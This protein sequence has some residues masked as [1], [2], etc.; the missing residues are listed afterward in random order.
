MTMFASVD[1]LADYLQVDFEPE[2]RVRAHRLLETATGVIQR[3]ARQTFE[4]VVADS[5]ALLP[6]NTN[7]L[8]LPELP[9]TDVVS[10]TVQGSA[11]DSGAYLWTVSG[12]LYALLPNACWTHEATVVYDHGFA[13][14]PDDIVAI[15]I[16]M[17]GRAWQNPRGV[18]SEQ[19]GTYSA[20]YPNDRSG[21]ILLPEEKE[22]VG[23]YRPR[24]G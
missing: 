1:E 22:L 12:L 17:A 9:V 4:A 7:L 23:S 24:P 3:A 21:L 19:I 11:M 10:V 20:R 8:L 13:V 6:T 16:A 2:D 5:V 18:L 15:T 14:I